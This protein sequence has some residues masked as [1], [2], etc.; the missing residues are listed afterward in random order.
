MVILCLSCSY[1]K[2]FKY[3]ENKCITMKYI[4]YLSNCSSTDTMSYATLLLLIRQKNYILLTKY[5]KYFETI[6]KYLYVH[7]FIFI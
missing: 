3:I 2:I 5:Y 1:Q 7:T 4:Y 6:Q